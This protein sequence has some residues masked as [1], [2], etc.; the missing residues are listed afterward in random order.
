MSWFW[1]TFLGWHREPGIKR[2]DIDYFT[3]PMLPWGIMRYTRWAKCII[4]ST[5]T[6]YIFAKVSGHN[7][8]KPKRPKPKRTQTETDTDRNGHKPKRTQTEKATNRNGHKPERPQTE[9]DTDRNGH[10]PKRPQTETA[11]NWVGKSPNINCIETWNRV[12]FLANFI[13]DFGNCI[14]VFF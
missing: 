9:T 5:K 14:L 1:L 6:L 11:T 13:F 4:T 10:K 2:H 7:G 12:D 8:H 3:S